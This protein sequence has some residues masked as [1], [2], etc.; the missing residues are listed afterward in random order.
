MSGGGKEDILER[1]GEARF[2]FG[3]FEFDA[4]T[5]ELRRGAEVQRLAPQPAR[6]LALLAD[7]RGDLV[8]RDEIRRVVWS[9]VEVDFET[10]LH[11]CIRQIRSALA[12]S[13]TTPRYIETLPRR[14]YRLI[15]EVR[16]LEA[17]SDNAAPRRSRRRWPAALALAGLVA[18]VLAALWLVFGGLGGARS[19]A[20]TPAI[21]I[22][23]FVPP[24]E[25]AEL[26][27]GTPLADRILAELASRAGERARIV[28]PTTTRTY[29]GSAASLTELARAYELDYIVNGRFLDDEH[30]ARMLA[31]LIRTSDGAHVWVQSYRSV[32]DTDR[33]GEEI[34]AAVL[35]RLD[36][37]P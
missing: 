4:A 3:E 9:G 31:E 32:D 7:R 2:R 6:V 21:A 16:P 37:E 20:S 23:P 17:P 25:T 19:E 1:V 14:G 10:S 35:A 33:I 5:G 15:P 11:F 8:G 29:A 18:L 36:L 13:A 24:S 26:A 27:G 28:G 30:G 34:A 12:D 22:M